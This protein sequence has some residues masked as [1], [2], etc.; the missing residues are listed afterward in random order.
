MGNI[1][2]IF[3]IKGPLLLF[4]DADTYH[5]R[6][7]IKLCVQYF[8]ENKLDA[9]NL[10]PRISAS[11]FF[12]KLVVP[13][14]S[15]DRHTF[16][17]PVDTND[18]EKKAAY[19]NGVYYL[20]KKEVY[21]KI[22]THESYRDKYSADIFIGRTLKELKFKMKRVRGELYLSSNT[23]RSVRYLFN[24]SKLGAIKNTIALLVL[25]F[26]PLAILLYSIIV[27]Q[28]KDPNFFPETVL[29]ILSIVTI[30]IMIGLCCLQ[31]RYASYQNILYG[32]G[33]P[34]AGCIFSFAY[35][36][37]LFRAIRRLS[38]NWREGA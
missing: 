31:S 16:C 3:E 24:Q 30:L 33:A 10:L 20:I 32:F 34:I 25:E 17:S 9:L 35:A 18:P 14:Y 27:T 21:Q 5:N 26:S 4:S 15:L 12:T 8:V 37:G 13:L 1:S 28:I 7:T 11:D 22:G 29:L 23:M 2:R 36:V 19:F 38:I 6:N